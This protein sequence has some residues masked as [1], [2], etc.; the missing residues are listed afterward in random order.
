MA[1]MLQMSRWPA[2]ARRAQI[3][4]LLGF[5]L[6][7]LYYATL[8]FAGK[9]GFFPPIERGLTFNSMLLHLLA[10]RFDV[11]P[12]VIGLEGFARGGAVYAYFGIFP[13]LLRL[14]LLALPGFSGTDFTALSC[15]LAVTLMALFKLLSLLTVWRAA[16]NPSRTE[17]PVVFGIAILFSGAQVQF[18]RPS[19]Y[20][21]ISLWAN[22][23]DAGFIYLV[24]R[25]YH[26]EREFTG[27]L[28]GWLALTAGLCLLT[29]VSTAIGLYVAFSLLW[30]RV[31]WLR[32]RM[33]GAAGLTFSDFARLLGPA[34]ILVGFVAAAAVVNYERWG[35]PLVFMDP[36]YHL[37]TLTRAPDRLLRV[38]EY[39]EFNPLRF[40]YGLIYYFFPVWVLHGADGH[41]LWT[42]FQQRTIDVVELPPS[43]FLISD[44]LLVGLTLYTLLHLIK[45]KDIRK[46]TIVAAV[47]TGLVIPIFL[48]LMAIYMAFRYRMEFYPFFEFASFIAFGRLI[49]SPRAPRPGPFKVA[50]YTGVVVALALFVLYRI[51]PYGPAAGPLATT[52]LISFYRTLL[53]R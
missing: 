22:V 25:G 1:A 44:P 5:S 37:D 26:S 29:R 15:L 53:P 21:E 39:G 16:A 48:M 2:R 41:L 8:I 45:Q 46:P 12:Q 10:G 3:L 6:A 43:S 17:L 42:E 11:D 32:I 36:Q 28:L 40:G 13:A 14:P 34:L 33:V 38:R 23:F 35:N 51:S 27:G 49:S 18:L 50:A 9:P 4:A 52:D 19:V 7:V 20:E 30:L 31:G 24:L 47:L